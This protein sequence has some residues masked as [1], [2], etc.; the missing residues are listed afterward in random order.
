VC[1]E[2]N[3]G[4]LG[5]ADIALLPL[6]W[7]SLEA[8]EARIRWLLPGDGAMLAVLRVN[9][10]H[11]TAGQWDREGRFR[12]TSP[13]QPVDIAFGD[14]ERKSASKLS[15]TARTG[16]RRGSGPD[17]GGQGLGDRIPR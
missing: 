2:S 15:G 17:G 1:Q 16:T 6:L 14:R 5:F 7:M 10:R 12:E 3:T 13:A 11:R 8:L 4:G 9:R